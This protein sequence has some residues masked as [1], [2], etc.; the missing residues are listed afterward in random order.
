MTRGRRAEQRGRKEKQ[1]PSKAREREAGV[2]DWFKGTEVGEFQGAYAGFQ[3]VP[4]VDRRLQTAESLEPPGQHGS[5][6]CSRGAQSRRLGAR[7]EEWEVKV[8]CG[9][10]EKRKGDAKEAPEHDS[11]ISSKSS[12]KALPA[13]APLEISLPFATE[14]I[15][16]DVFRTWEAIH[17]R[18]TLTPGKINSNVQMKIRCECERN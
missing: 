2:L 9:N 13:R 4:A 12:G 14:G 3:T 1:K 18:C 11:Y 10:E 5:H 8:H 6:R 7:R 15:G 17:L 16:I